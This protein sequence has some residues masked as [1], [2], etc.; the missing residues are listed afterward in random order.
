MKAAD[1]ASSLRDRLARE[2]KR[3]RLEGEVLQTAA[4]RDAA[5]QS[6]KRVSLVG[7]GASAVQV[8]T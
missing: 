3:L 6:D 4:W 5:D 2:L 8:M 7:T 1:L